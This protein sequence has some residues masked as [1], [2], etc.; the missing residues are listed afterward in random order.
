MASAPNPNHHPREHPSTYL[1]QDRSNQEELLR[2]DEQD[3]MYTKALGGVLPEQRDPLIFGRVLDVG[4]GPGGWLIET[5]KTYP[6]I[7]QLV[8]VDVSERMI[9]YARR[10]AQAAG[11]H[12]RVRFQTGDALRMLEFPNQYFGLV[13]QRLGMSWLR[14]WDW[15]R[16]VREYQRVCHQSGVIRITEAELPQTSSPATA[17][18]IDL[19]GQ[20][21]SHAGHFFTPG[22]DGVTAHLVGLMQRYGIE[23]VQTHVTVIAFHEDEAL[24]SAF[25]NDLHRGCRTVAPFIRKWVK[26]ADD[27]EKLYQQMVQETRQAD[28][29]IRQVI[30]T[31]WGKPLQLGNG[32]LRSS[33]ALADLPPPEK[34]MADSPSTD[35]GGKPG[36]TLWNMERGVVKQ[37]ACW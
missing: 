33:S 22:I 26:F 1:V 12:D 36:R 5:A 11:V 19:L 27:Y 13:N 35:P 17:R 15:P 8:G 20:A 6:T 28:F 24:L 25:V 37:T 31:A 9:E 21:L 23:Q 29:A 3:Q 18:L 30:V 2:L 34:R 7:D 14:K 4:C 16:L 10:Q 32:G